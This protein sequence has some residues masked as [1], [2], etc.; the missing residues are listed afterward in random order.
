MYSLIGFSN[1][2]VVEAFVF[3][4]GKNR[5]RAVVA[6]LDDA[7]ELRRLGSQW[8][9]E[10][11]ESI[12]LEFLASDATQAVALRG[13]RHDVAGRQL[14]TGNLKRGAGDSPAPSAPLVS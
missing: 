3:P 9:S 6:G 10:T 5:I 7:L 1:A 14:T 13:P 2:V 8:F 11:G 12:S 4:A